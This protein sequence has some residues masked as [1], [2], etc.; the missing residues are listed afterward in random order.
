MQVGQQVVCVDDYFPG[1]LAKYYAQ[2]PV[3]GRTYTIR[4]VYVGRAI[5]HT[6]TGAAD[7]EIGVLLKE[8]VNGPDPRNKHGLELGFKA[9]RFRPLKEDETTT[10]NVD[11]LVAVGTDSEADPSKSMPYSPSSP[12]Q[13]S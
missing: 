11:E 8:L 7:G 1:P 4:A 9:E 2:L 5:M 13:E 3:K 10:E 6:Q 12:P